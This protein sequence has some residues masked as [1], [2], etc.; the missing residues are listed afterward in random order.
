MS[1]TRQPYSEH[2]PLPWK[3]HD[4]E[5]GAVVKK[6]PDGYGR[7]IIECHAPIPALDPHGIEAEGNAQFVV[8]ACNNHY[9]LLEALE[10]LY[11][12]VDSCVELTPEV[13]WGARNAIAKAKGE[14]INTDVK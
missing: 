4:V 11:S 13:M 6:D 2:T 7:H 8:H 12:A 3:L 14:T 9:E 10:K 5:T 1:E